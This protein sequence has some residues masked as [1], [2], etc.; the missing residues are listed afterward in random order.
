[1]Q[2]VCPS[3]D[4]APEA[5]ATAGSACGACGATLVR[6]DSSDPLVGTT[7]D[8]RFL[9][10]ERLGAGAMGTVYRATQVSIGRDV[11]VKVMTGM[12]AIAVK[13]FFREAQIASA[14]SHPNTVPIIEFGQSADGRVYLAMELVRGRTLHDEIRE[15][16]ALPPARIFR[17]GAQ[18]CDALATAHRQTI[19]HR[20]LKPENVMIATDGSD[21]VRILDFGIARVL[22]DAASQVTGA[23]LTAGTPSY[24]APEVLGQGA[25]PET[26]QD[27]YALG[28]ILA[29]LARG[30]PLWTGTTL[31]AL[32]AEKQSLPALDGVPLRLRPVIERLLD[33]DPARRPSAAEV[34]TQLRELERKTTDPVGAAPTLPPSRPVAPPAEE[35]ALELPPMLELEVVDLGERTGTPPA[36]PLRLA[37]AAAP[38]EPLIVQAPAIET[39]VE[40]DA[41]WQREKT[42]RQQAA[43]TPEARRAA[44]TA[45]AGPTPSSSG[46]PWLLIVLVLGGLGAGGYYLMTR[47]ASAPADPGPNAPPSTPSD[48]RATPPAT[49]PSGR[50]ASAPA[51]TVP[52]RGVTIRIVGAPGTPVAIDGTAAGKTP[53]SLQRGASKR[54]I[55]VKAGLVTFQVVPDRDQTV[56]ITAPP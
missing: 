4:E 48:P 42:A 44:R 14:L 22:G 16:G 46:A 49:T 56:D 17:I 54:P 41:D 55:T 35:P 26:P 47:K 9:I 25:D 45:A 43:A 20:D 23:G 33:L 7:L 28:V 15:H 19:V 31:A 8:K 32:Y 39:K 38:A 21:H 13:R 51:T 27:M 40:L 11:A 53:I 1:M 3:C 34:R 30:R 36:Q 6:V 50:D 52:R 10:R 18:L 12:D 37:P 5:S 24:M 2:V 29:E